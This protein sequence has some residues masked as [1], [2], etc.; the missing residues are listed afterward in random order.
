MANEISVTLQVRCTNGVFR[1]DFPSRTF[2]LTQSVARGAIFTQVIGSGAE[3]NV[4]FTD[5]TAGL[6]IIWNMDATNYVE[7][8]KSDGGTMKEIMKCLPQGPPQV[9]YLASGETLRGLANTAD[10]AV[11]IYAWSV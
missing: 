3:E 6:V 8:G 9:F 1:Q 7:F 10:C 5:F 2:N 11:Q 4:S